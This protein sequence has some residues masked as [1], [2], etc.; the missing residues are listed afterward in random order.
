M[1]VKGPPPGHI[2]VTEAMKRIGI[3]CRGQILRDYVRHGLLPRPTDGLWF[4]ESD[5]EHVLAVFAERRKRAGMTREG[6]RR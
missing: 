3:K 6:P 2:S 5:V 4:K 1:G